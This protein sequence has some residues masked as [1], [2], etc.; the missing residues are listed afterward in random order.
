MDVRRPLASQDRM[1]GLSGDRL[2]AAISRVFPADDVAGEAGPG[3]CAA[4]QQEA[5]RSGFV[6]T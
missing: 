3:P 5:A 2:S 4:T 1:D 6:C